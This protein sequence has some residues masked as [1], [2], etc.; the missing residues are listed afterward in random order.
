MKY[1]M[2]VA[3]ISSPWKSVDQFH[4]IPPDILPWLTEPASL[5]EKIIAYS[6]SFSVKVLREYQTHA[7]ADEI[8]WL[9]INPHDLVWCREVLLMANLQPMVFAHT[10]TA[11]KHLSGA[12]HRLSTLGNQSLGQFLF[13][14]NR[15]ERSDIQVTKLSSEHPLNLEAKTNRTPSLVK[16][17]CPQLWAR[18]SCF[19]SQSSPL[20]ISEVF[21]PNIAALTSRIAK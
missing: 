3:P 20:L 19:V 21:Y 1:N 14:D 9:D 13:E 4:D 8:A 18:R 10:V 11:M 5:T 15:L 6:Q 2:R 17:A 7:Y 16:S 12:W